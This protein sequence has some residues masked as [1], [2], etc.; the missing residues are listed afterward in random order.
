MD[1]DDAYANAAY[2]PDA[3]SYPIRWANEADMF[4]QQMV[5][6][7]RAQLGVIYD[8]GPRTALDLFLPKHQA[9]GVLVFV[10][11]GYWLKFGRSDFS[12]FAAGGVARGWAVA[13]PSY[14]LCPQVGIS[15][16]TRQIAN[17]VSMAAKMVAGPLR[18]TGHSAGGHL[19]ARMTSQGVLPADVAA[20]LQRAVPISPVSD[21][22]PLRKTAMNQHFKMTQEDAI[23]ES[24]ALH[25]RPSVET[26]IWVG[27]KERPVFLDQAQWLAKA[28]SA[29]IKIAPELH[30]FNVINGLADPDSDLISDIL[31]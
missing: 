24:P 19:S 26:R 7:G 11:G 13:V 28:W 18:I 3:D 14:D 20:R 27:A 8:Q 21:L 29:P 4:R 1:F 10:H 9:Q 30:H 31:D 15:D 22:R 2:I 25:P 6:E 17:A 16:I 5:G 12:Y 23:A